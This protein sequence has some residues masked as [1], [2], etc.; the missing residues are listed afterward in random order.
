MFLCWNIYHCNKGNTVETNAELA[1]NF[2]AAVIFFC[3]IGSVE[4]IREIIKLIK[5]R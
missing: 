1:A 4:T 3:T 2:A 5:L